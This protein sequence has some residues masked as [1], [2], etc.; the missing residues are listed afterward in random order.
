VAMPKSFP[1]CILLVVELACGFNQQ[2][3]LRSEKEGWEG[4]REGEMSYEN[5][6]VNF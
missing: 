5:L 1:L 6:L 3:N 4:R 2:K